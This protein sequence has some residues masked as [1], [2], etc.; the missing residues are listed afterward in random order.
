MAA[1]ALGALGRGAAAWACGA[2]GVDRDD[3]LG[4]HRQPPGQRAGCWRRPRRARERRWP[5]RWRPGSGRAPPRGCGSARASRAASLARH[6]PSASPVPRGHAQVEGPV[7]GGGQPAQLGVQGAGCRR[8]GSRRTPRSPAG[9]RRPPPAPT[10]RRARARAST[11]KPYFSGA[12]ATTI[13]RVDQRDVVLRLAAQGPRLAQLPVVVRLV[14]VDAA[15][16]HC[17]RRRCSRPC[18]RFQSPNMS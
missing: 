6:A 2:P 17:P 7:G 12:L 13:G 9:R 10:R 1:G 4:P 14:A 8:P 11:S 15:L 16:H 18:A 5:W 3:Q